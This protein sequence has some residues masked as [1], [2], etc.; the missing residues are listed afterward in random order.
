MSKI[1]NLTA[2]NM[3]ENPS[4]YL[5]GAVDDDMLG[6]TYSA[7]QQCG[8]NHPINIFLNSPGGDLAI[9]FSVY[10][11]ILNHNSD[12]NIVVLGAVNSAAS[13]ILQ[14]A[15]KRYIS[16]HSHVMIHNGQTVE[17]DEISSA[18]RKAWTRVANHYTNRMVE[19]YSQCMK[20]SKAEIKKL[21]KTDKIYIG[22]EAVDAGLVD[23]IW[24]G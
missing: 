17:A 21:I 5:S 11:L 4:F 18:E 7:L 6:F 3:R 14:A 8:H 20:K 10:D 16:K 13:I 2:Y 23:E 15:S 9:A 12:T 19:I 22:Q 1:I 24:G